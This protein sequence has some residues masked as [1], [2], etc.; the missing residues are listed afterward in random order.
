[1][2]TRTKKQKQVVMTIG[3]LNN[4]SIPPGA[5]SLAKAISGLPNGDYAVVVSKSKRG[6]SY[7][8]LHPYVKPS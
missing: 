2:T 6:I 7:T 3:Q 5:A 4:L 1:M 8:V